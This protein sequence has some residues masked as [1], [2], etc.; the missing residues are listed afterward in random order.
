MNKKKLAVIVSCL[1]VYC[2][3]MPAAGA[4]EAGGDAE[5]EEVVVTADKLKDINPVKITEIKAEQ[6]K[7]QG[8]HNAAEALKDV[9]GVYVTSNDAMGKAIA[10]FRGSDA[11]NTKVFIDGV[12]LSPV[13]DGK[14]DLSAIAAENIEKIEVFKGT[15]PVV[16]GI[17]APGGVILITTKK[18]GST[19]NQLSV[20]SGSHRYES[21]FGSFSGSSGKL[22]YLLNAKKEHTDGY[23]V[24]SKIQEDNYNVKF[25]YDINPRISLTA[26]G[27]YTEKY[28]QLPNRIDPVTGKIA[29]SSSMSTATTS[30]YFNETYD[31]EYYPWKSKYAAVVFNQKISDNNDLSLKWYTTNENAHL[32][33]YGHLGLDTNEHWVH[34]YMN[35][36]V[37]GIELQDTLR[38]SKANTI[39]WGGTRESKDYTEV[40]DGYY[41]YDANTKKAYYTGNNISNYDY[42]SKSF[43]LQDNLKLSRKLAVNFGIR[44]EDI[45]DS[46]YI[47]TWENNSV[48]QQAGQASPTKPEASFTYEMTGR[49]KLHGAIGK[50]FRWPNVTE[51]LHP[52]GV[53]GEFGTVIPSTTNPVTGQSM[54][55]NPDG[56]PVTGIWW[57]WPNGQWYLTKV[58]TDADGNWKLVNAACDYVLPEEAL[59]RE[60][61]L[62]H[63]FPF[64]L[65]LDAT[66]FSK[67]ITNMIKGQQ[68]DADTSG[69][70]HY[71]NIPRVQMH[72]FEIEGDY[73]IGK[74]VKGFLSYSYTHAWD[75]ASFRQVSDVPYRKFSYGF[76]YTGKNG[77]NAYLSLNYIGS[78]ATEL[79][80]GSNGNGLSQGNA[81]LGGYNVVSLWTVP[82][83]QTVDFKV[84]KEKDNREYYVRVTN[85][86]D[87][88]Y[89][90]GYY[91]LAPG[92]CVE[93]GGTVKF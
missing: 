49:T 84:S 6:I 20:T 14:V 22:S 27:M 21:L 46:A 85:L 62:T 78:Y 34:Q 39:I 5:V 74:R 18:G 60:I 3:F 43:Y 24:H 57:R 79:S 48:G 63:T 75:P 81:A 50:S 9:P 44:H 40:Q 53:Y 23:T 51:R 35:G 32:K 76:T 19:S 56:S 70:L 37:R 89:Y 42:T 33:A 29:T 91:L 38:T 93:I 73:P 8:A 4:E 11:E 36:W 16:Y 17:N 13:G 77:I 92:R 69:D 47:K 87:K 52:G 10:S 12:P 72:G 28:S 2:G 25:N 90:A 41:S 26:L 67:N 59:N 61:G 7:A 80:T 15:A 68:L 82:G 1:L 31:W 64:G 55:T 71:Y 86:F 83:H 54:G 30:G 88:K 45:N 66:Y 58:T 65:K